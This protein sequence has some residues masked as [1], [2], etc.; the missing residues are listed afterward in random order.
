MAHLLIIELPGGNDG[1][2]LSAALSR[3]DRFSIISG[4]LAHYQKQPALNEMLQ[5]AERQIEIDLD[6]HDAVDDV[7]HSIH[8]SDPFQAVL[9]LLD[10]RLLE[11]AR[12]AALLALPHI[13][14]HVARL[15]R[16][17]FS[18][19][20][21]LSEHLIKQPD[22]RLAVSNQ[23][24]KKAV[25]ELG[26]PVLIK[27]S[28]GFGSQNIAVLRHE[29]D[30]SPWL[31]PLQ[32]MLP[33]RV[34]YGLGVKA[35]DRLLVERYMQGQFVGCDFMSANGQHHML[36]LNEKVMFAP[37][38]FAIKGGCF[39][40]YHDTM[41]P[42]RDYAAHCLDAVGF[43][44]GASHIEIMITKE[45][46]RLVEINGRLV[47][48]RIA[49]LMSYALGYSVHQH[50]IHLLMSGT[51]PP[52]PAAP[53]RVAVSRWLTSPRE[54]ILDHIRLPDVRDAAIAEVALFKQRGDYVCPPY[55]NAHRLGYVMV[56][57]ATAEEAGAI[58][59][60]Y[61]AQCEITLTD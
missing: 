22:F 9:C 58:A 29:N 33:S 40:P 52:P 20:Q 1:D 46:P 26:L 2:I 50:L 43:N 16:D 12:I 47:G 23:D 11:A 37:P 7:L 34:D 3:G 55:E 42:L 19:R 56:T 30:L 60:A 54:G 48:A 51:F 44:W 13:T 53:R 6:D 45:G 24:L 41:A 32:D 10:L 57:A 39:T 14:V 15:L 35:N 61:I 49:R 31:S 17:K 36:G 25:D 59:D 38:S 4:N 8:Q 5:Q 28:D 27:P 21:K 18:V